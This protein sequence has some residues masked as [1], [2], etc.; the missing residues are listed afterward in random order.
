M[1]DLILNN[2]YLMPNLNKIVYRY[3]LPVLDK[4][5]SNDS[6]SIPALRVK[7]LSQNGFE[8]E[9]ENSTIIVKNGEFGKDYGIELADGGFEGLHARAIVV[10]DEKGKVTYT[11]LVS[12]IGHEPN[13]EA[14]LNALS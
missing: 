9:L 13:Y 7:L 5:I 12:E 11:E 6:I 4:N 3:Q 10:V 8:L 14:A 1:D 2:K